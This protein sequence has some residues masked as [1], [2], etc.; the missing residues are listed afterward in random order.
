MKR[1][2]NLYQNIHST[3]NLQCADVLAQTGKRK[4]KDV[5]AHIKNAD[6]DISSLQ[7]MLETKSYRT[8][9]YRIFPVYEPKK[10]EV[11]ALPYF[12]D[13]PMHH[14][15]M[16]VIGPILESTFVANT[17]ACI[18]GRGIYKAYKAIRKALKDVDNTQY[19]LKIDIQKFYPSVDHDILKAQLRRK[20]KDKDL[21]NLLDELIDSAPGLPIGNYPS[22]AL[23]C[24]YLTPFDRWLK[25]DKKIKHCFRYMD[26]V[27][28]LSSDKA[29]LHRLRIEIEEWLKTHLKLQL[30]SN[31]QVFPVDIRGI[32][33]LGFRFFREYVLMRDTIKRNFC[34]AVARG[35]GMA[36]I[37]SY[38]GWAKHCNSKNLLKKLT[39]HENFRRLQHQ[40]QEKQLYRRQN[41]HQTGTEQKDNS[42][43]VQS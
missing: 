22:Q 31:W 5:Q 11:Y 41:R 25:Q 29:S 15:L 24:F 19:C 1:H 43:G 21:L 32:D 14:A 34:R 26:D 36:T 16:N 27:V 35:A 42:I 6:A 8:S 2:N 33:V 28:I 38:M 4:R 7:Q 9:Q 39:E 17:Y 12:P 13:R 23:S 30:K 3:E 18:K 40:K 20:F 37:D 10:R